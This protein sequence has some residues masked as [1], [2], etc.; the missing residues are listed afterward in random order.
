MKEYSV[1]VIG[2]GSV[3]PAKT[4]FGE[5]DEISLPFLENYEKL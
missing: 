5:A 2:G 1:I 4:S 3:S